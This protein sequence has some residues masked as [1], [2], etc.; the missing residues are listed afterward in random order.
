M[1]LLAFCAYIA[2]QI[3]NLNP[4]AQGHASIICM[5]IALFWVGLHLQGLQ[6]FGHE[7]DNCKC[8]GALTTLTN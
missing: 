6:H 5:L 1:V 3:S 4:G 2:K 7:L 8:R